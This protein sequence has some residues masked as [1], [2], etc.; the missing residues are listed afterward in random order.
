VPK[1]KKIEYVTVVALELLDT[2]I[3]GEFS[4]SKTEKKANFTKIR[5]K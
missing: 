2:V 5:L 4:G 3:F 1:D